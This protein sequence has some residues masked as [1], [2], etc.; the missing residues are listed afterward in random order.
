MQIMDDAEIDWPEC[1]PRFD[2]SYIYNYTG[3]IYSF[4]DCGSAYSR[5]IFVVFKLICECI[6]LNLFIGCD[7]SL[8]AS[9][10][11]SRCSALAPVPRCIVAGRFIPQALTLWAWQSG[12]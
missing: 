9:D 6:F 4:G 8:L 2:S 11:L 12:P 3:R 1:T 5:Y 10:P 7:P